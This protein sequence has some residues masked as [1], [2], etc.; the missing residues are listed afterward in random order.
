MSEINIAIVG[1]PC[2]GKTTLLNKLRDTYSKDN[3]VGF[4]DEYARE[5]IKSFGVPTLEQHQVSIIAE[6][7]KRNSDIQTTFPTTVM[8]CSVCG[9]VDTNTAV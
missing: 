7:F 4:V 5:Y 2:T 8:T 3:R 6:Q 9:K 1:L